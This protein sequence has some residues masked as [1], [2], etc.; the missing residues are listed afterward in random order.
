MPA[1]KKLIEDE[2]QGNEGRRAWVLASAID[3]PKSDCV[4]MLEGA[5]ATI[6]KLLDALDDLRIEP[7][8]TEE[9]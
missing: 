1:L 3:S 6:D 4:A 5:I 7:Q 8:P 2:R 9:G